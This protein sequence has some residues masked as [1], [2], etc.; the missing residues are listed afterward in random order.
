[1]GDLGRWKLF[2]TGM[3]AKIVE[4]VPIIG[5]IL[6]VFGS[7][8]IGIEGRRGGVYVIRL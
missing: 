5:K 4:I 6:I 1:M 3:V 8:E 7:L 2:Q